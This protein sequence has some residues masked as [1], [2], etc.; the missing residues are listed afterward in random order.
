M[1]QMMHESLRSHF[2]GFPPNAHPMAILSA[3]INAMSCYE[4]GMMEI[5]DDTTLERAAARI[6]S[7]VRTIAAA[8]YKMSI[9]QP[10]M[11]PASR[12]QILRKLPAHDVFD[13]LSRLCA[14]PGSGPRPESVP[15]PACRS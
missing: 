6:I 2:E 10:L 15:D 7:K 8:S 3:M 9:G 12:L 5:E 13:S 4:P 14:D 1:N 11:Y